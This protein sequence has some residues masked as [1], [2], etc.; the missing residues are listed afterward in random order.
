MSTDIVWVDWI[1]HGTE[2]WPYE[3]PGCFQLVAMHA[4][5]DWARKWL[6]EH[7]ERL[8]TTTPPPVT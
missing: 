5:E 4:D 1:D 8:V 7:R 6:T 2:E 3:C